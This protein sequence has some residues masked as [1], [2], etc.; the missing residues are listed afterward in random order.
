MTIRT[1]MHFI[2]LLAVF[3]AGFFMAGGLPSGVAQMSEAPFK[4][5]APVDE[6][7][8]A[9][10]K[11][12]KKKPLLS[13]KKEKAKPVVKKV[14][15]LDIDSRHV[16]SL[17]VSPALI[18]KN[19]LAHL[20]KCEELGCVVIESYKE[21]D[22]ADQAA[23]LTVR[24]PNDAVEDFIASLTDSG[25]KIIRHERT[26]ED[27]TLEL[28]D[29]ESRLD[30]VKALRSSM[31]R[32]LKTRTESAIQT[33]LEIEREMNRIQKEE[34]SLS[35]QLKQIKKQTSFSLITIEYETPGSLVG[36]DFA[37]VSKAMAEGKE[38][39]ADSLSE[40]ILFSALVLPWVP[41]VVIGLWILLRLFRGKPRREKA[42]SAKKSC[43]A[44]D[45]LPAA[46]PV[47]DAPVADAAE[48]EFEVEPAEPE[49]EPKKKKKG[50]FGFG[51]KK[52]E[53]IEEEDDTLFAEEAPALQ[54]DYSDV[55]PVAE[56]A[57]V[58]ETYAEP[59]AEPAPEA[60]AEPVAEEAYVEPVAEAVPAEIPAE[61][62]VAEEAAAEEGEAGKPF[63]LKIKMPG[64]P[65]SE[66]L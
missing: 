29:I 26:A 32:L 45:A 63:P 28:A 14:L 9:E 2:M 39:F 46:A 24:V 47:L 1:F 16:I 40:A 17:E 58:E 12:E 66:E 55:P 35:R 19:H 59:V 50:F 62:M 38:I 48:A 49:D 13:L 15:P 36:G 5:M 42:A 65:P 33:V 21:Q 27:R 44:A 52:E 51:K 43:E 18:T 37:P 22:G 53:P 31:Q 20:A 23:Y 30:T 11:E 4:M 64:Q 6:A 60:Y 61:E 57:P 41:L 3:V 54:P 56:P 10:K 34:E 25:A 7:P 8:F